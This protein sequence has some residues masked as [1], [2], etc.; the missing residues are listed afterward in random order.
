MIPI[1][2]QNTLVFI[3]IVIIKHINFYIQGNVLYR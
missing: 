3:I 2:N 1:P